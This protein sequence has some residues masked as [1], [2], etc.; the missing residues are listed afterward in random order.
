MI[1]QLWPQLL[2]ARI[3]R[4][5]LSSSKEWRAGKLILNRRVAVL[6]PFAENLPSVY[7]LTTL[8]IYETIVRG[9]RAWR[10]P[11]G[12]DS[13]SYKIWMSCTIVSILMG[14]FGIVKYFKNGPTWFLSSYVK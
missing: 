11:E 3:L 7:I 1:L 5:M 8:W 13:V 2:A 4:Q 6:K 9:N 14:N 12:E 10:T